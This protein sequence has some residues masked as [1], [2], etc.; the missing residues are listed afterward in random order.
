[1]KRADGINDITEDQINMEIGR[2]EN[3]RRYRQALKRTTSTLITIAAAAVLLATLWFPVYRVTGNSMEP[4]LSSGQIILGFRGSSLQRGDVAA[5]YYEN[6][7]ILRRVVAQSG[8][9]LEVNGK[10]QLTVEGKV[11]SESFSDHEVLGKDKLQY[12]YQVPDG[13]CIVGSDHGEG[14]FV[15]MSK[16]KIA[17]KV[18][19]RIWPLQHMT[20]FG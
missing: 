10:G 8:D 3:R 9:W 6:N 12:P 1:M 7:V 20:Y 15:F 14:E 13:C 17:A 5:C 2:V 4:L 11:V 18:I 19:F 16:E